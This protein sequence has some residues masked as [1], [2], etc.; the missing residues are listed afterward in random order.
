MNYFDCLTMGSIA[1]YMKKTLLILR[2]L[3]ESGIIHGDIKPQNILF[4]RKTGDLKLIDFGNAK[5]FSAEKKSTMI[6]SKFFRAP[7]IIANYEYYDFGVDIWNLGLVFGS[8]I[9][10]RYPLLYFKE[11]Q[12]LLDVIVK[13]FGK[14]KLFKFLNKYS[15]K[16]SDE[17][18]KRYF[19]MAAEQFRGFINKNN[20]DNLD[21]NVLDLL[22]KM[23][24][25]DPQER[26]TAMDALKH[27][28]FNKIN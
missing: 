8:L 9:F 10:R 23:L 21:Q 24:V 1:L 28:F 5:E 12:C 7:E 14:D 25:I 18:K 3:H 22:Q 26:I 17:K 27:P 15:L 6:G 16:I 11:P 19:G 20:Q 2:S 13:M 4:N